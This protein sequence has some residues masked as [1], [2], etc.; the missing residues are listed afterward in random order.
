MKARIDTRAV[1]ADFPA[2]F[3]RTALPAAAAQKKSGC[4]TFIVGLLTASQ[5]NQPK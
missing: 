5:Y 3:L 2:E 1:Q 4:F